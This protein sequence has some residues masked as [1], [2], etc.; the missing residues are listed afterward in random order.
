MIKSSLMLLEFAAEPC[1]GTFRGQ[2][3]TYMGVTRSD[4]EYSQLVLSMWT[5][6]SGRISHGST[7][8]DSTLDPSWARCS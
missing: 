6:T 8:Q 1:F 3:G 2:N 4:A 5:L 7:C